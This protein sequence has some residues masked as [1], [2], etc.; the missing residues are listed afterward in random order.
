MLAHLQEREI[1][2]IA[3]VAAL[4]N[5]HRLNLMPFINDLCPT[6]TV[7][8][9]N[10]EVVPGA[11][12]FDRKFL[13]SAYSLEANNAQRVLRAVDQFIDNPERPSL[14]LELIAGSRKAALMDNSC[15]TGNPYSAC[16]ARASDYL[17]ASR[18]PR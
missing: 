4:G 5:A 18:P 11:C 12:S 16:A 13:T 1:F 8:V 17:P 6:A 15:V 9:T 7:S 2:E 10:F 3:S 14:N